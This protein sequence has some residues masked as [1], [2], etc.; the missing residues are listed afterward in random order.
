[1]FKQM[2]TLVC[3][4]AM[5][6]GCS[7]VLTKA[8][9]PCNATYMIEGTAITLT[10]GKS[11]VEVP[12]SAAK[13]LTTLLDEW[14][15]YGDVTDDGKTDTAAI[16]LDQPGGTGSFYYLAVLPGPATDHPVSLEA[17]LLGD[18]I[19]MQKVTVAGGKVTVEYLD[20]KPDE[21]MTTPPSVKVTKSFT[22]REGQL[23]PAE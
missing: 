17:V 21:P 12:G 15:A 4:L 14:T 3:C 13:R 16:L 1:M 18:R 9:D 11:E 23:V 2:L 22:V 8:P 20:R 10:D 7:G 6:S 5:L 19:R